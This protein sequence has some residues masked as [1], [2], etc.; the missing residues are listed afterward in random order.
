MRRDVASA[1][2]VRPSLHRNYLVRSNRCSRT[3]PA[4]RHDCISERFKSNCRWA[5]VDDVRVRASVQFDERSVLHL[6]C[7]ATDEQTD[8]VVELSTTVFHDDNERS[9]E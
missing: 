1:Q 3:L 7:R 8:A 5:I 4:M 2:I 9:C 6:E